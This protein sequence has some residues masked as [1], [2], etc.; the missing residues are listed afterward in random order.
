[1]KRIA[2]IAAAL[3]ATILLLALSGA[4][5]GHSPRELLTILITGSVGST[6]ALQGTVLKSVPLL[7][8]G[9]SVVIAFRAGV[10]NI[11]VSV[12]GS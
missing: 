2:A 3:L 5:F 9:L 1:M 7:L 10:W 4:A 8:T 11:G 12:T 6:F